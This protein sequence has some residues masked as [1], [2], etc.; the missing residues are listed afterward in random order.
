ML[1]RE[2]RLRQSGRTSEAIA[3]DALSLA[4]GGAAFHE[5]SDVSA[6]RAKV[7]AILTSQQRGG[8]G[9]GRLKEG[10]A[11]VLLHHLRKVFP[12]REKAAPK[13]RTPLDSARV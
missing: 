12:A 3:A 11:V 10:G 9:D 1:F 13:V 8:F 4:E 2:R 6:E 5:E 7:E